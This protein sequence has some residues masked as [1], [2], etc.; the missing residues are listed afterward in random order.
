MAKEKESSKNKSGIAGK[1]VAVIIAI[2]LVAGSSLAVAYLLNRGK[3]A[4]KNYSGNQTIATEEVSTG[5]IIEEKDMPSLNEDDGKSEG[6]IDGAI[7]IWNNKGYE[8]FKGTVTD[9]KLYAT[10]INNYK[11]I[12]GN[13]YKVYN[14]VVPSSTEIAL[15]QRLSKTFS[16]NQR[17]NIS[18]IITSLSEDVMPIDVYNILC[19]KR[20]ENLYYHTEKY[21]TPI[22]AYYGYTEIIK[23]MNMTPTDISEFSVVDCSQSF[24]GSY[25]SAT[26]SKETQNGNPKLLENPDSVQYYSL[27][28]GVTTQITKVGDDSLEAID[29]FNGYADN[30]SSPYSIYNA[31]D[32]SCTILDNPLIEHKEKI[33][34]VTDKC[35]YAIAPFFSSNFAQVHIIDID[36]FNRNIKDYLTKNKITNVLYLNGIT[37]ANTAVKT[38][39]MDAMF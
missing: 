25:I 26:V 17:E 38:A 4:M 32:Y 31:T 6:Y 20:N 10:S 28:L 19:E 27:P 1:V 11:R 9:A 12:L 8:I 21:W 2:A 33:A 18:T 13:E 5:H 24:L 29:Y 16:N 39:K 37:S 7:Y 35:G 34:I 14:A 23:A 15:P 3:N 30:G 22:G 36:N